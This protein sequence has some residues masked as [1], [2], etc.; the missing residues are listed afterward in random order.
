MVPEFKKQNG[1]GK[2]G[3]GK[4]HNVCPE[5]KRTVV[6]PRCQTELDRR[7]SARREQPK[8]SKKKPR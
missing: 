8:D 3:N 7:R 2:T 6:I 5:I 1:E 4:P